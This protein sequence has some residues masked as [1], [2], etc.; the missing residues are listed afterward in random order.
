MTMTGVRERQLMDAAD[1]LLD[2]RR[3]GM[4]IA[5][6]PEDS[7]PVTIDEAYFVQDTMAVAYEEIGGWKVGAPNAEATPMFAPMPRIWI[8]P[9]G[10]ELTDMPGCVQWRYRGVEAEIAFLLGEDLPPRLV[11]KGQTPYTREEVVAA[12]ASCHPAIEVLES[13]LVDPEAATILSKVADL[14]MHGGFV[15]GPACAEWKAIDFSKETVVLTINGAVRVE[16]RGSNTSGDL[17]RLLPYLA[18]EGAARTGGLRRGDWITTGSWT[19]NVQTRADS[20]VDV[21]FGTA[22]RVGLRFG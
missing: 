16:R 10:A 11:A 22:G 17:M 19:G 2:A 14:Q 15:Y 20:S 12:I 13:G 6:L 7:R 3:T 9:N 18:N 4:P 5:D 8:A 1:M 21:R